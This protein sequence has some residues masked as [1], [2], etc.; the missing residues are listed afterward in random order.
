[1][2]RQWTNISRLNGG[3][4]VCLGF[5][6]QGTLFREEKQSLNAKQRSKEAKVR[7]SEVGLRRETNL[8]EGANVTGADHLLKQTEMLNPAILCHCCEVILNSGLICIYLMIND[9]EN[10]SY[11][12]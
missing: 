7:R 11:I 5:L 10:F 1:M 12:C 3:C 8:R 4:F 6:F 2:V 9:V